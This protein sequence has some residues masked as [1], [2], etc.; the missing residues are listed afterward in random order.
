M[1]ST[2]DDFAVEFIDD[3]AGVTVRVVGDVDMAT[4]GVLEAQLDRAVEGF[5]GDVTVDLTGVTFLDSYRVVRVVTCPHC[6]RRPRSGPTDGWA[7]TGGRTNLRAGRPAGHVSSGKRAWLSDR[8]ERGE[9][10]LSR[11]SRSIPVC[12]T[13]SGSTPTR[14]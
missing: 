8:L 12:L 4:A 10:R 1:S 5:A 2:V 6:A 14:R 11:A 7:V 13:A 9:G 3:G